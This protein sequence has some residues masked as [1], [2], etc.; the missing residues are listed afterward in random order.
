MLIKVGPKGNIIHW[1][2]LNE[3]IVTFV[4]NAA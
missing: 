2:K 4:N 1:T 3:Q